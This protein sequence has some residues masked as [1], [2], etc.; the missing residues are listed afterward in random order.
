MSEIPIIIIE[1]AGQL[2]VEVA[3]LIRAQNRI[4]WFRGQRLAGRNLEPAIRRG[5]QISDERNFTNRFR[6]RAGT[7]HQKLPDYDNIA[8]WLSLMQHHGMPTRLLDWTRSPLVAL[9][10]AVE[11]YIYDYERQPEMA[12]I[13]VLEPHELNKIEGHGD[14]TPSIEAHMCEKMIVPAFSAEGK[15]NDKVMAVMAAENDIRMFVQ[16]GCFTIHSLTK[17]LEKHQERACFLKKIVIPAERVRTIAIEIDVC[18]FRKGDI[19]PDLQH[20]ADELKGTYQPRAK[21]N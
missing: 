3:N 20:L 10:F 6:C 19:F 2:I 7:R 17:S 13:W 12:C 14:I 8:G 9:Y 11:K 1:S 21:S 4:L 5:Y 15:E 16:Q 18:G